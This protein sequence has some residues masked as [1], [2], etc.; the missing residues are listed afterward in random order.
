MSE[1]RGNTLDVRVIHSGGTMVLN[2]QYRT[3]KLPWSQDAIDASA[4]T[5]DWRDFLKGLK[6][7]TFSYEGLN[8][9]AA[10]PLGTADQA[11]LRSMP[12]GTIIVSPFGTAA[13]NQ[14][15]SGAGFPTKVDTEIKYDDVAP[16]NFE[17]QGSGALSEGVW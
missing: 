4:G 17:W 5:I 7:W 6:Q 9:G 2:D 15:L 3:V 14:K 12:M 11:T 13:G 1:F 8:N 16:L 10:S